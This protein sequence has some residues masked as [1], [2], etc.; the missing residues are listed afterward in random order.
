MMEFKTEYENKVQ[1]VNQTLARYLPPVESQ[2]AELHGAMRY[3]V[4]SGGKRLRGVLVLAGAEWAGGDMQAVEPLAAAVEC[5]HAYSLIHDDLPAMD[6][7]DF[8]RGQPSCHKK[9]NE[10]TAIL[11]GDA[12]HTFAFELVSRLEN[13]QAIPLILSDLAIHAGL[14]GM[15]TGQAYDLKYQGDPDK[16]TLEDVRRIHLHKTAA[17]IRCSVRIGAIAANATARELD[18]VSKY[19]DAIGLGFQIVDDLLDVVGSSEELGKTAGKDASQQKITYPAIMG[20]KGARDKAR[21]C[22]DTAIQALREYPDRSAFLQGIADYIL[23]R[24]R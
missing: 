12:L 3:A 7:D 23:T 24:S 4:L 2:P 20:L 5:I 10:A 19:G 14:G 8:R 21:E 1:V 18:T 13:R 16:L 9:Y 22:I 15:I 6:D 11:A 17:I